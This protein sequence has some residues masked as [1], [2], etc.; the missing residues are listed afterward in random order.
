MTTLYI[1]GATA[2]TMNQE[3]RVIDDAVLVVTDD[4]ITAVGTA[5]EI[6]IPPGAEIIDAHGMIA[7]PGLIDSHA[8]AGHGLTRNLGAGDVAAW[9]DVCE[10]F[11]TRAS[12]ADFWRAE[13]R[14][15]AMERL[16]AGITTCTMLLGGGSDHY[17]TETTEAGDLHCA[18][19][20]E[21]GL[22]TNL[23]VGPNQPPF[24]KKYRSLDLSQD[25]D[26]SFE[27]QLET[28]RALIESHN[29]LLDKGTGICLI[30]PVYQP[31][32][33]AQN[34][35]EIRSMCNDV[36][37]LRDEFGVLFTQDGHRNGSI[38]LAE[39]LGLCGPD[40]Y[41]SHS[42]DL[43]SEDMEAALRTNTAIVHNPSAIM[44]IYGRCPV[45]E[46]L[47][48]GVNVALGSDAAAPDRGYDM[49]RHMAQCLHYHRR[50]FRDPAVLMPKQVIEMCTINAA[51]VLGLET[52][53]GSLEVGKKADIVLLDRQKAHLFPPMMPLTT[54]AQFA[55]AADVDTVIV[56]GK[57]CMRNRSILVDEAEV[58]ASAAAELDK[59]LRRT[60]LLHL[61]VE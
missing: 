5:T 51:K 14:L 35:D 48:M 21:F 56:N 28:C 33:Y 52:E 53:L 22:R 24:P 29:D 54:V 26:V 2:I 23:A 38:A 41:F 18:A 3:R 50:H 10:A 49:F 4:R 36:M 25:I 45:P 61:L 27:Q 9:F 32:E 40:S 30:M 46:L 37:A 47:E 39:T 12:T 13:A 43:T 57:I 20:R 7:L 60:G 15:S 11:Y 19:T 1:A 34:P 31:D 55:N 42:V 8:H 58:L 59:A 6:E 16:K 44:S 17:R